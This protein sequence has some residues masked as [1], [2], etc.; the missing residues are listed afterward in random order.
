MTIGWCRAMAAFAAAFVLTL[1][2]APLPAQQDETTFDYVALEK[3]Y[4][5]QLQN[6]VDVDQAMIGLADLYVYLKRLGEAEQIYWYFAGIDPNKPG[7]LER[8]VSK[9]GYDLQNLRSLMNFYTGQSMILGPKADQSAAAAAPYV[10]VW[11]RCGPTF[12]TAAT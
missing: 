6:G 7:D 9:P 8:K 4:K 11:R 1:L 5:E 10:S 2:T 12:T 3:R